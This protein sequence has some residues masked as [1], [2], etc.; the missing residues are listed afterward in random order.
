MDIHFFTTMLS[1]WVKY[2]HNNLHQ[3]WLLIY[4]LFIYLL[5][6]RCNKKINYNENITFVSA[7]YNLL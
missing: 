5:D 4:N 6:V 7:C 1:Y 2:D 3:V